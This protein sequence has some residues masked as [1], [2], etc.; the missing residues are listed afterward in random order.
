MFTFLFRFGCIALIFTERSFPFDVVI[1]LDS[2]LIKSLFVVFCEIDHKVVLV[3][4]IMY[5]SLQF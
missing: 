2:D 3:G 1:I 5:K 4:H